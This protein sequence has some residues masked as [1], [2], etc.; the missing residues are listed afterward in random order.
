MIKRIA[1]LMGLLFLLSAAFAQDA[2]IVTLVV[3]HTAGS[4]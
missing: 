2:R 4:A 1:A 3:P